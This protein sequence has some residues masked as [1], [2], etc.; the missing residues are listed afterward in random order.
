[1]ANTDYPEMNSVWHG[2]HTPLRV[3]LLIPKITYFLK[4]ADEPDVNPITI[5]LAPDMSPRRP[6]WN[7]RTHRRQPPLAQPVFYAAHP[8]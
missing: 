5:D 2:R 8:S 7:E 6:R 3:P 4:L 1:M